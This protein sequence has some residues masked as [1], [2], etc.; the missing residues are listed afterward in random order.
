MNASSTRRALLIVTNLL[1]LVAFTWPFVLPAAV[2]TGNAHEIDAPFIAAGLLLCL[3]TV[4]FAELGR[5]GLGA[6]VVALI[7][8]LGAAMV[9]LRLPGFVGGF[10]AM[11]SVVLLAGNSFGPAFGFVLGAVGTFASGLFVG[12]L[13][14]WLPFQMVAV[15]WVGAGAGLIGRPR[16]WPLRIGM[17]AAYGFVAAFAFGA[18][19]NLWFWPF[20]VRDSEIGWSA[21]AGWG[22][23]AA[24]YARF[25]L[26]TSAGWDV[27][28]AVGNAVA[29]S[30]LG[31]AVLGALDRAARRMRLDLHNEESREPA[32]WPRPVTGRGKSGLHR[33]GR[34]GKSQA[35]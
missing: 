11:F 14:P 13:G 4:L 31:R 3:A 2:G 5:G 10:S 9:A 32:G 1:G 34:W 22:E 29:M 28:G 33:A 18:L 35:G 17:L 24:N 27:F 23:N 6:K 20:A 19:M 26:V 16:R 7:G 21:L 15:G 8:V 30:V 25:Y 12:G